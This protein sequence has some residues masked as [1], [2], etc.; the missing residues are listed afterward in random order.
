MGEGDQADGIS[1]TR[2]DPSARLITFDNHGT[3]QTIPLADAGVSGSSTPDSVAAPVNPPAEQAA[4]T[5]LTQP[6]T[7]TTDAGYA[8]AAAPADTS[9]NPA[10]ADADNAVNDPNRLT[11]EAQAI[12]IEAQRQRLQQQGDPAAALMPPTEITPT[13]PGADQTLAVGS[14][15]PPSTP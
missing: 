2:I 12:L 6:G 1:V 3:V 11:P 10:V 15:P 8:A 4:P 5:Q 13:A 9:A 14:T 7:P